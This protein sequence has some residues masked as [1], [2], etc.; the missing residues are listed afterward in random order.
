[1]CFGTKVAAS[2]SMAIAQKA[3]APK[4]CMPVTLPVGVAHRS[5]WYRAAVEVEGKIDY[6][7]R[8]AAKEK[9][10]KKLGVESSA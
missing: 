7:A 9:L 6:A 4:V 2:V 5:G 10:L 8:Q 1:M 3:E